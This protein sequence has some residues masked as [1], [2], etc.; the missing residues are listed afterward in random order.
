MEGGEGEKEG[1]E[2]VREIE[3]MRILYLR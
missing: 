2:G 1:G 3:F